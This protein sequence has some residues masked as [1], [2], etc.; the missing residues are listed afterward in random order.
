MHPSRFAGASCRS[1]RGM[2]CRP[3]T[4]TLLPSHHHSTH[5]NSSS[6]PSVSQ[7]LLDATLSDVDNLLSQPQSPPSPRVSTNSKP[8][9][10]YSHQ[11]GHGKIVAISSNPSTS[12]STI[13]TH[14]TELSHS[15]PMRLVPSRR[16]HQHHLKHQHE[17]KHEAA[18]VHL[19]SYGGGLVPGDVLHLDIDVRGKGATLCVLTQGGTRIYRPGK[20]FRQHVNYNYG[21]NNVNTSVYNKINIHDVS[22][23]LCQSTING[24]VEPGATLFFLPDPTVPYYQSSFQER[25]VFRSQYASASATDMGSI[26]SV[27]WYSSGRKHS[28]GME[29]ERWAFDYL[30]SRTELFVEDQRNQQTGHSSPI[31]VE[32]MAFDNTSSPARNTRAATPASTSIGQ[33]ND[34]MA[35]LLLHGPTS[36]PIAE[37]A[38]ELSRQLANMQTRVR[39]EHSSD[40]NVASGANDE[41]DSILKALG[42]KVVLS[43]TP[44]NDDQRNVQS[45]SQQHQPSTTHVVRILAESNEDIYRIL[46]YCLKSCSVY[47]GGLE[48]YKDRIHSS[49]TVRGN[50]SARKQ[51]IRQ[52]G[53]ILQQSQRKRTGHELQLLANELIFGNDHSSNTMSGASAWFRMCTLSDSALPVGSFAHSLG[54]EAASQMGLFN[55]AKSRDKLQSA[56]EETTACS[57][58]DLSD[59]I[60]A[61]SRSNAR[62]ATPLVLAGYSLLVQ[63]KLSFAADIERICHSWRSIDAYV[64]TLLQSNGPGRRASMDQGLGLLRIAP[65]FTE[66]NDKS[67]LDLWESIRT[68]IDKA[69][70]PTAKGHAAPI[71]GMLSASLG[72]SPLDACRVFAFGAARDSVS[73]AVRLNLLGPMAGVTLL[74]Q[75]GRGA[76]DEGLEE[77]LLAMVKGDKTME[78]DAKLRNWLD[79]VATCAPMMD[80]V[81]PCH[82]LLSVRLFRT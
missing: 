29:E 37:K 73:A 79:S 53:R 3:L 12:S 41:L 81:Q 17:V 2:R 24:K 72:V 28:A 27:D 6:F 65:S 1:V 16:S 56:N 55:N 66:Y 10:L 13:S 78:E 14:L 57:I 32:S 26:I 25:R 76:V 5:H 63:N 68:S 47:V 20:H 18:L 80:T 59:Y 43:V 35:S 36:L 64:D 33:N 60:Y 74:D 51:A 69:A 58:D 23:K 21:G 39:R 71:Y 40:M 30:G 38:K 9:N 45:D 31:L 7:R 50:P 22:S 61:V 11:S 42:G 67:P 77:G 54:I 52:N 34:S 15:S 70:I 49:K 44:V 62:F 19:S 8:T 46:H 4:T 82:D 48:P 75:V